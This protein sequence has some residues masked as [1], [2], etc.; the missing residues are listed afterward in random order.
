MAAADT[1]RLLSVTTDDATGLTPADCKCLFDG[2]D[3]GTS[4]TIGDMKELC[5]ASASPKELDGP[6]N[7][8]NGQDSPE[9][10]YTD[11]GIS[12]SADMDTCYM[13]ILDDSEAN[14]EDY[15]ADEENHRTTSGSS[16]QETVDASEHEDT[17][18]NDVRDRLCLES[19][20]NGDGTAGTVL[21]HD[22]DL[23]S[24]GGKCTVYAGSSSTDISAVCSSRDIDKCDT[25]T[26]SDDV[27]STCAVESVQTSQRHSV[28]AI[29]G[30]PSSLDVEVD[31]STATCLS[32]VSESRA[33]EQA[34]SCPDSAEHVTSTDVEHKSANEGTAGAETRVE[35]AAVVTSAASCRSQSQPMTFT[36]SRSVPRPPPPRQTRPR[37]GSYGSPPPSSTT[38]PSTSC[39]DD[40]SS[41]QQYVVNVHVNPGETFSVCV[42]DQ[43][44]LIQGQNICEYL[45]T[46]C[47]QYGGNYCTTGPL[48]ESG[49]DGMTMLNVV[50]SWCHGSCTCTYDVMHFSRLSLYCPYPVVFQ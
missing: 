33:D 6:T 9:N 22:P 2:I 20:T 5:C 4:N 40:E 49:A 32:G 21:S 27:L 31:A 19:K 7:G 30:E 34:E 3:R 45:S 48:H 25:K 29:P 46:C 50:Y 26:N 10:C 47:V 38:T 12:N 14:G 17:G 8:C 1:G 11:S 41:K 13:E 36:S 15:T 35:M 37:I 43:V 44:Q 24:A 23:V 18:V 16:G 39:P 28:K 42:S